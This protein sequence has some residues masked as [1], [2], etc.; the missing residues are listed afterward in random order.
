MIYAPAI[1]LLGLILILA[2]LLNGFGRRTVVV[3]NQTALDVG[4]VLFSSSLMGGLQVMN[5][6]NALGPVFGG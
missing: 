6:P 5:D 2:I 4:V 1:M 3:V